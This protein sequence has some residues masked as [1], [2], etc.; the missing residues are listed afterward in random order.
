ML[1]K[2]DYRVGYGSRFRSNHTLVAL[3]KDV[4]INTELALAMLKLEK[5][6]DKRGDFMRLP[7]KV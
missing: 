7:Y 2:K 4:V 1:D 3:A 5:P 6:V